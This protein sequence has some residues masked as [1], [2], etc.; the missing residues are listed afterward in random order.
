LD[1]G[2][3]EQAGY[4]LA[5]DPS[6]GLVLS[7]W[8]GEGPTAAALQ[9]VGNGNLVGSL[10]HTQSDAEGAGLCVALGDVDRDGEPEIAVGAPFEQELVSGTERSGGLIAVYDHAPTLAE[11]LFEAPLYLFRATP[12]FSHMGTA[13]LFAE[14]D[15]TAGTELI[16]AGGGS[17]EEEG[18]IYAV[19]VRDLGHTEAS[20]ADA[21]V[22]ILLSEVGLGF[23]VAAWDGDGDGIDDLISTDSGDR[24]RR[25]AS[26]WTT[27][28]VPEDAATTWTSAE[29]VGDLGTGELVAVGDL[30]G[31]GLPELAIGDYGVQA[32]SEIYRGALYLAAG[33][34]LD[35]G[36]VEEL[37]LQVRGD[38][39]GEGFGS[40]AATGDFDGDGV[41]DLAMGASGI[42]PGGEWPGKVLIF[43]GPLRMARLEEADATRVITGDR[44]YDYFGGAIGSADADGDGADDLVVSAQA[45]GDGRGRVYLI[46]GAALF[47]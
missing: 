46:T 18:G 15:P 16:A 3:G 43:S 10:V 9:S 44:E 20:R 32:G 39:P 26:P 7:G 4:S 27:D 34:D 24:V 17:G 42:A 14:L 12:A 31:D 6:L 47:P 38:E 37:P 2:G 41:L 29:G 21:R 35:G 11:E 23:R 13:C 5:V 40:S 33:G 22:A 8:G 25:F 30:T 19:P 1:G 45:A 28:L 36:P